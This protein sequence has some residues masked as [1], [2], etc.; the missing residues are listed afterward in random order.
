MPSV[1]GLCQRAV[2]ANINLKVDAALVA[3]PGVVFTGSTQ[4]AKIINRALAAKDGAIVPL[5]AETGGIN[6]MVV[7]D[8]ADLATDVGPVVD[9]EAYDNIQKHIQRLNLESKVLVAQVDPSLVA[10][11]NIASSI[12]PHAFEVASIRR[13][14][15]KAQRYAV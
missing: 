13:F 12:A 15:Y 2:A 11:K 1:W 7:G 4:V 5:I 3:Q 9:A 10:T 8:T 14:K 6:A